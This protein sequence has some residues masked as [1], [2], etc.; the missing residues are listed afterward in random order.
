MSA[1]TTPSA[2]PSINEVAIPARRQGHGLGYA[3]EPQPL[4]L[5]R[6]LP[7]VS[8]SVIVPVYNERHLVG[9][10][11]R[12]LLALSAPEISRIEVIVV[13]DCSTDGSYE[14]VE[15]IARSDARVR[16]LRHDRNQG[17]G[18]AVRT[19]IEVATGEI[20]IFHDADLEYDPNDMPSVLRPFLEAG[21]DAVFGSRYLS[22]NYRRVLM[23][24]HTRNNRW[25][26]ALCNWFSDLD[27]TDVETCYKA[28]R[29]PLLR[30]IPL[31]SR[32][33]RVEIELTMKLAKR[34]ARVFEVPIRYSPRTYA[35]GKKIRLRDGLY[36]VVAI[37]KHWAID[38]LYCDTGSLAPLLG[39]TKG[40]PRLR[41]WMAA[42]VRP[43]VGDR[44]LEIGA[45]VGNLACHFIPRDLYV[46]SETSEL[47]LDHLRSYALGKPYLHVARIDPWTCEGILDHIER[48]D[49][50]L[51]VDT[52]REREDA[53]TA[54]RN[55]S[56]TLVRGGRLI[57]VAPNCPAYSGSLD[58][59]LGI[60]RR[61]TPNAVT[62]MLAGAGL[63]PEAVFDL[64][65]F[66]VPA[67]LLSGRILRLQSW[68]RTQLKAIEMLVPLIRHVDRLVP[69]PGL[70]I[71]GVGKK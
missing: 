64:N 17:K 46:V 30:S 51:M 33:F 6:R 68:P 42:T 34:R 14:V 36:A 59:A 19:G 62:K 10:S 45:G 40:A 13:D 67:W 7:A 69:W 21:A 70:S 22:A 52:V 66:A 18:A 25:V 9:A 26:T 41:E 71:V 39:A 29:T 8:L 20:T 1:A 2:Q 43:Y 49:T 38:D 15:R 11:L 55:L 58:T 53:A 27:L 61:Y 16:V 37:L 47:A 50:V 23:Y 48:Y 28:V 12:G 54:V 56:R 57:L 35:E 31:R 3:E 32:D 4:Y 65:R 44:V 63:S 24:R 60:G 5:P